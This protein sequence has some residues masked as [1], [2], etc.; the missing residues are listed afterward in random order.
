VA[1]APP[2]MVPRAAGS[3]Y[4]PF[5]TDRCGDS[6]PKLLLDGVEQFNRGEYFEQHETLEILWRAEK[7][8]VRYL[9]QGILLV[10]VGMFHV[11]RGNY[12]GAEVKLATGVR[13]LQWF[14][15]VCQSVD[16]DALI[17]DA[18]RARDAIV[19]LGPARLAEL[20]PALAPKVRL[21]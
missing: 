20:D 21:R 18:T 14:R 10:G 16:V 17:A 4:G 2:L 12:H 19:S 3:R 11:R 8:D 1:A 15:P 5:H 9:Y 6:P 7:D 13:F